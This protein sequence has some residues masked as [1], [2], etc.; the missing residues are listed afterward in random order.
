MLS[1]QSKHWSHHYGLKAYIWSALGHPPHVL[2]YTWLLFS[3]HSSNTSPSLLFLV[4]VIEPPTLLPS[5]AILGP[6]TLLPSPVIP[7]PS[8]STDTHAWIILSVC[9]NVTLSE[10]FCSC[11]LKGVHTVPLFCRTLSASSALPLCQCLFTLWLH[12]MQLFVY[13]LSSLN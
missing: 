13:D 10:S 4:S 8:P 5:P 11:P 12:R 3:L 7:P 1:S 6:S 9:S 2:P